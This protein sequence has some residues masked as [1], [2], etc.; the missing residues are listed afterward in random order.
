MIRLFVAIDVPSD[1]RQRMSGLCRGITRA[2]WVPEENIHITL[3]FIG[4]VFEHVGEDIVRALDRIESAPFDLAISGAGHFETGNKVRAL[5]LGVERNEPL[6]RLHDS[7]E[8]ALVRAGIEP[9]GR[10]FTPHLTLARLKDV[11]PGKARAW[12]QANNLFKAMPF[13]VDRFVLYSSF[14]TRNGPLYRPEKVFHF[15]HNDA[16][17]AVEEFD[18]LGDS[19]V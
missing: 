13:R 6:A 11:G 18:D 14:L 9:N 10:R 16:R 2:N 7:V 8:S 3:R 12:L 17:F 19:L 5:W 1:L 15:A 4:E